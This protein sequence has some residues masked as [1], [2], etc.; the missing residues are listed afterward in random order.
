[1]AK[2]TKKVGIVG[3]YG[4][5]YG[6]AQRKTIKKFEITQRATYTCTFCGKDAVR[7]SAVGIWKCRGCKKTLAGGAWQ[8]STAA[9]LTAKAT[10]TRLR[11]LREEAAKETGPQ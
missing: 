5:R 4:T 9:A 7:R 6:A 1:M 8:V 2:R 10:V 11:R 3:K